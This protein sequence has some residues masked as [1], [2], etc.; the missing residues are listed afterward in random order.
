MKVNDI[1]NNNLEALEKRAPEFYETLLEC[2][3]RLEEGDVIE[4]DI[5]VEVAMADNGSPILAVEKNGYFTCMNSTYNPEMETHKYALQ[6]NKMQDTMVYLILGFGNGLAVREILQY[7][8]EKNLIMFYEPS[9]KMF[10]EVM[11]HFDISD[12]ICDERI[13]IFVKGINE[14]RIALYLD[15]NVQRNNYEMVYLDFLPRYRKLYREELEWCRELVIERK[16]MVKLEINTIKRGRR[17]FL[18]N[19]IYNLEYVFQAKAGDDF[20]GAFPKDVPAIMVSA[21]P[22]LSKNIDVLKQA[23]GK[24]FI[25]AVDR[26]AL[27]L[28]QN[29][30]VPDLIVTVDFHKDLNLFENNKLKEIPYA[31]ITDVNYRVLRTLNDNTFVYC[32]SDTKLYGELFEKCGHTIQNLGTGGSV[33]TFTLGLLN[34][35]GFERIIFTGQDLAWNKTQCHVGEEPME[36]AYGTLIPVEGNVEETV[37]TTPDFYSY[38]QWFDLYIEH[39]CIGKEIINATEGGARIK[40]TPIMPL[41]QVVETYCK[42]EYNFEDTFNRIPYVISDNN[43]QEM[44]SYLEKKGKSLR[45]LGRILEEGRNDVERL[46]VLMERKDYGKEFRKLNRKISKI[47]EQFENDIMSEFYNKSIADDEIDAMMDLYFPEDNVEDESIRLYKKL[48][49]TYQTMK[50]REQEIE[51]IY[52]DMI[53]RLRKRVEGN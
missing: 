11:N 1:Y 23:K 32:T 18:E 51:E 33:A 53:S 5:N 47:S 29:D 30:V 43:K 24:A 9:F 45:T 20:V 42:K 37:Y 39:E 35:W 17:N 13:A 6:Y 31:I 41:K 40:G 8:S 14:N 34:Y 2:V 48:A 3:K 21:G 49:A 4:D 25:V 44:F 36:S 52:D 22:S 50:S 10:Y 38:I 26:V 19:P 46:I 27:Y 7:A 28:L 12:L 15:S 16:K